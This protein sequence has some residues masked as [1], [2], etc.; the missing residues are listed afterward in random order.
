MKKMGQIRFEHLV[1]H[2]VNFVLK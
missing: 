1:A 2:N